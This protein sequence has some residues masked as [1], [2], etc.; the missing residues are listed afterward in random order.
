VTIIAAVV[1]DRSGPFTVEE[2]ELEQPREDEVAMRLVGAGICHTDLAMRAGQVP[3][4]VVLGHEGA[5]V[6]ERVGAR[7]QMIVPG[8]HVVLSYLSC[9]TCPACLRGMPAYCENDLACNFAAA[10]L[11]GS[12]SLRGTG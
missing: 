4:P 5:G 10:R 7:V 11:D 3:L 8:D 12:S 6:V 2:L 9:G 1:R